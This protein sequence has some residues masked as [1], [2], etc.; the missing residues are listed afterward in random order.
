MKSY[1]LLNLV[2]AMLLTSSLQ[3]Q[4][5]SQANEKQQKRQDKNAGAQ[6]KSSA[7][8]TSKDDIQNT[9]GIVGPIRIQVLP[10]MIIVTGTDRDEVK[11][12]EALI[13][14]LMA[15]STQ[16]L[17]KNHIHKLKNAHAASVAP[18]VQHLYDKNFGGRQGKVTVMA[19][20]QSEVL[21]IG[22]PEAIKEAVKIAKSL[23]K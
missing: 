17:P 22:A 21:I 19:K 20:S 8:K 9:I 5:H 14:K 6:E 12:V 15:V 4:N 23:D 3:A 10:D 18:W 11:R 7:K 13:H 2:L 16:T 1:F